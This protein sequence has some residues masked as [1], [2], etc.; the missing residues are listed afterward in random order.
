ME[1]GLSAE[2]KAHPK[3]LVKFG[4]YLI[5]LPDKVYFNTKDPT[6]FGSIEAEF[7]LTAEHSADVTYTL[8]D[9]E[10]NAYAANA[11]ATAPEAPGD[12]Q[13]WLDISNYHTE[14]ISVLKQ[15][16]AALDSWN[17]I[18]PTYLKICAEGIGEG[19]EVGDWVCVSGADVWQINSLRRI[20]EGSHEIVGKGKTH[21]RNTFSCA[22]PWQRRKEPSPTR[23]IFRSAGRC[24]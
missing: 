17:V 10:G 14:H 7:V 2:E 9:K 11:A 16:S 23:R 5:V 4:S 18:S 21:R 15:Y 1:L 8:C 19:F 12:G 20:T 6:D 24:R 22:T 3:E 13:Y